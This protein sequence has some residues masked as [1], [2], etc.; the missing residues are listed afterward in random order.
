LKK[1]ISKA[2]TDSKDFTFSSYR[3]FDDSEKLSVNWK[4]KSIKVIDKIPTC[5]MEIIGID[6]TG[7]HL[8]NTVT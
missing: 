4:E 3:D 7:V 6:D 1:L 5:N 2:L 8:K